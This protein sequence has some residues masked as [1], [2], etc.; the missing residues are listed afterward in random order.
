M[1]LL[2]KLSSIDGG[3]QNSRPYPHSIVFILEGR[4]IVELGT[5]PIQLRNGTILFLSKGANFN[6]A[7]GKVP[8]GYLVN[9]EIQLFERFLMYFPKAR[10][11]SLLALK[12]TSV[13]ISGDKLSLLRHDL[14]TLERNL[15][16]QPGQS[17]KELL[18][19]L[20]MLTVFEGI[21]LPTINGDDK[22]L[23]LSEFCKLIETNFKKQRLTSFYARRLAVSSRRLND[24]CRGWFDGKNLFD[25][26]MDRIC[27]EAE[28]MLLSSDVPVKAVAYDLGF[29]STQ[30]F[31]VYLKRYRGVTPTGVR[32]SKNTE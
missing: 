28:F 3:F 2:N 8:C 17:R 9:F 7:R 26:L 1:L 16:L 19:S 15:A 23:L 22:N 12:N 10:G 18:F 25:V 21:D 31:R 27:S 4:G 30:H 24:L 13:S 29:S 14:A 11:A 20:V 5:E 6:I 32:E